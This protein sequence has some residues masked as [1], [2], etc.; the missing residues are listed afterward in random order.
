MA[1]RKPFI[2]NNTQDTTSSSSGALIVRGGVAIR[3]ST[4]S[5]SNTNGGAL[6]VAGGAAIA[7]KLFVGGDMQVDGSLSVGTVTTGSLQVDG[8]INFTGQFL[9]NGELFVGSQ[10]IGDIGET[11]SYTSGGVVVNELQ[12]GKYVEQREINVGTTTITEEFNLLSESTS[13]WYSNSSS[14]QFYGQLDDNSYFQE[15]E[16]FNDGSQGF[17]QIQYKGSSSD[18]VT[19]NFSSSGVT[20]F[21]AGFGDSTVTLQIDKYNSQDAL[22]STVWTSEPIEVSGSEGTPALSANQFEFSSSFN[23]GDY[24]KFKTVDADPQATFTVTGFTGLTIT[25]EV[26]KTIPVT[27]MVDVITP[28][29][30]IDTLGNMGVRNTAPSYA[31]DVGGDINFTGQFLQNGELFVGSQWIGDIGET[32]SYTSG[33][34][35][36]TTNTIGNLYV[37]G[38]TVLENVVAT[39]NV[40]INGDFIVSGTTTTINTETL[41]IE[42]N[43]LVLNSAPGGTG[44]G[45]LLIK[46]H[47]SDINQTGTDTF[48]A[49]YYHEQSDEIRFAYTS[50][51]PSNPGTVTL[52]SYLPLHA[53]DLLLEESLTTGTLRVTG[54][55]TVQNEN[56]SSSTIGDLRVTGTTNLETTNVSNG[57]RMIRSG[58]T[59][60]IQSGTSTSTASSSD[61]MFTSVFADTKW[62]TIKGDSGNVGIGTTNPSSKLHVAGDIF[63]TGDI[64]AFSDS[65]LKT[66]IVTIDGALEKVRELRGVYYTAVQNNK[67]SVGVIAQEIQQVLPEVVNDSGE[68]LG[69]AYGN[70]VGLLIQAVKELEQKLATV[71]CNCK[72]SCSNSCCR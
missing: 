33:G 25:G 56:V 51:E 35:V 71:S 11:I 37:I 4:D 42:D 60:Y 72:C 65:R 26:E 49:L 20:V 34:V 6:T 22:I 23:P 70:I 27:E 61:L 5:V 46:R 8:D 38:S 69:V 57:I 21:P 24:L 10:W 31:L 13:W 36:T 30:F 54:T 66:D 19:L 67:K 41:N 47:P 29:L 48:A 50:T 68:Y 7:K 64:T 2:I 63:A 62:L 16:L 12:A 1:S 58:T 45:G 44:D 18:T 39:G 3:N 53:K 52:E 17:R 43:L 55:S 28:A 15:K 9:Q 32:I 59:N 14:S 40:Q